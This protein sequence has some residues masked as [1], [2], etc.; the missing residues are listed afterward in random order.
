MENN[1]IGWI[2]ENYKNFLMVLVRIS[3]FIFLMPV[4]S[5]KNV[6]FIVKTIFCLAL[7]I[8]ICA[9]YQINITNFPLKTFDYFLYLLIE[10]FIGLTISLMLRSIFGGIQLAAQIAGFQMGLSMAS[11]IDPSTGTQSVILNEF[12]F[13]ISMLLFFV[14]NAHHFLIITIFESFKIINPGFIIMNQ[15][16]VEIVLETIKDMFILSIKL[17]A[18]VIV[19]LLFIQIAFGILAKTSPQL[20]IIVISFAVNILAGLFFIG[21][22][23]QIFWPEFAKYIDRTIKAYPYV[24]RLFAG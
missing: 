17:M 4:F 8:Y 9:F 5:N 24:F 13:I 6:P 23:L 1:L 3:V 14:T 19:I 20:N 11:I 12:I 2:L 21:F 15:N 18:P 16:I 7:S 10:L 22:T